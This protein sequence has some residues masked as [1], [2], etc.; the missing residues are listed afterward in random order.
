MKIAVVL[1]IIA[2]SLLVQGCANSLFYYPSKATELNPNIRW[3]HSTSGN[4][5]AYLWL[6]SV[7]KSSKGLVIHFHGNN[8]HMETTR[9]KVDWLAEHGYHVLVFD[10][11][12]FGHSSGEPNDRSI[13]RDAI[14][15]LEYTAQLHS[16]TGLP[17]FIVA[18]ST[19][20]NI[21][22]RAWADH[23]VTIE[24]MI[25]DSS[26]TS[27][28]EEAEFMLKKGPWGKVYSWLAHLLMR[29]DYA[30]KSVMNRLANTKAL[31]IHCV[32]DR[33]VPI[34]SG[35]GIYT[36]LDGDKRFWRIEGCSHARAMTRE[37]PET[38]LRVLNWLEEAT[39][40]TEVARSQTDFWLFD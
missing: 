38:Q 24:G 8:G 26:F 18:T 11:S 14:S 5:I 12:G 40:A 22:L 27:Y 15:I 34:E 1:L 4:E 13:Y 28:V 6:P 2:S 37:F 23:P 17:V 9:E 3:M 39:P 31:V 25:I 21:F 30:A 33:V 10:Y 35:E 32:S 29:D 16:I 19:G 20:G 36:Q 7:R